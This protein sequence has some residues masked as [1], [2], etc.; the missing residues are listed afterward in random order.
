MME[1]GVYYSKQAQIYTHSVFRPME[2]SALPKIIIH[3]NL[4]LLP[5]SAS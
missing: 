1:N 5:P 4:G 3:L 2:I